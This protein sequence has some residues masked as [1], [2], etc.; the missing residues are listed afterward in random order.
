MKLKYLLPAIML[1]LLIFIFTA[2]KFATGENTLSLIQNSLGIDYNSAEVLN[3]IIRKSAHVLVF[4]TLSVFLY[5]LLKRRYFLSWA[6]ATIY[7][8]SDEYHQSF[9]P[10]RTSTPY[11][12][13]LDSCAA[14]VFIGMVRY[15]K[16]KETSKN[17]QNQEPPMH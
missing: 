15:I 8:I 7:A 10:G 5:F 12:V 2:S 3:V 16:T 1:G 11:D 9:V 6:L 13:L 17:R 14:L 4:G